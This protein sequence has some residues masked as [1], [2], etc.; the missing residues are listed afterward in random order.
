MDDALP[1]RAQP[2]HPR[3]PAAPVPWSR[4]PDYRQKRT[5]RSTKL[6]RHRTSPPGRI[7]DIICIAT[8]IMIYQ[9][10]VLAAVKNTRYNQQTFVVN[11]ILG[12]VF[13]SISWCTNIRAQLPTHAITH[14]YTPLPAHFFFGL[15]IMDMAKIAVIRRVAHTRARREVRYSVHSP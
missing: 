10:F 7:R 4:T 8:F 11:H 9:F 3:C 15:H 12:H 5:R 6:R 13:H 2:S 14:A 1:F